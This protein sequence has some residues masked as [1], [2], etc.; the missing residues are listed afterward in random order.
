MSFFTFSYERERWLESFVE[1]HMHY[2]LYSSWN[3]C[4]LYF[5]DYFNRV[6]PCEFFFCQFQAQKSSNFETSF[7][8][9]FVKHWSSNL[10]LTFSS[11]N[12]CNL[13]SILKA[14]RSRD[15]QSLICIW[16]R[17]PSTWKGKSWTVDIAKLWWCLGF[18]KS[19]NF[20][21]FWMP[22]FAN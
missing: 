12:L 19:L 14:K 3:L 13:C 9:A 15:F 21:G 18:F 11:A 16:Y 8:T 1:N 20:N 10:A 6:L 2:I 17:F 4:W 22:S 7:L 5:I